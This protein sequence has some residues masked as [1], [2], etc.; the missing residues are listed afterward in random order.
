[1]YSQTDMEAFTR[2]L[3]LEPKSKPF[4]GPFASFHGIAWRILAFSS[5]IQST[6][7]NFQAFNSRPECSERT[8]TTATC[9]GRKPALRSECP[10]TQGGG[11]LKSRES[12]AA[13]GMVSWPGTS[14]MGGF[15]SKGS[16]KATAL[17]LLP[18]H[19]SRGTVML[20]VPTCIFQGLG[21]T[22]YEPNSIELAQMQRLWGTSQSATPVCPPTSAS[23]GFSTWS[24]VIC[25]KHRS[26]TCYCAVQR[27]LLFDFPGRSVPC[28]V[29]AAVVGN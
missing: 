27:H 22:E 11:I 23:K 16:R 1:M 8:E 6:S 19:L 14:N 17:P 20:G 3:Q 12:L 7:M 18:S 2:S 25:T 9:H 21:I 24:K 29:Q 4:R 15:P 5:C 10:A 26:H 13:L 28:V